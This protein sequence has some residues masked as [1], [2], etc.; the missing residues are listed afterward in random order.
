MA[1]GKL[2]IERIIETFEFL[3]DWEQRY[4]FLDE[5]GEKLPPMDPADQ[6]DENRVHQCMSMVWVLPRPDPE[7]PDLL[8]Y[9]GDCDTSTIKGVVA[10]LVTLFS[11]KTPREIMD[12]DVDQMFSHLDLFE[13]LSPTRH[14]GVYAIVEKMK[15]QA[16]PYLENA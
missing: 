12:T 2:D 4:Q 10:I 16:A 9:S 11:G 7:N 5:L 8:D 15:K 13:H 6:N 3:R 1:K 14:V